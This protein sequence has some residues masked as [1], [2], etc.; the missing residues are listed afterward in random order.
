MTLVVA[1]TVGPTATKDA[2]EELERPAPALSCGGSIMSA[3]LSTKEL[4]STKAVASTK[5]VV[6]TK[7]VGS[8]KTFD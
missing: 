4:V 8:T 5:A 3:V 1:A 7:A 6:S 2:A